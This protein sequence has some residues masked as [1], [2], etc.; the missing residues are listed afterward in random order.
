MIA[1]LRIE[2]EPRDFVEN[3]LAEPLQRDLAEFAE[4]LSVGFRELV[5]H[6]FSSAQH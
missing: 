5:L 1:P 2:G 6:R 3:S 4:G